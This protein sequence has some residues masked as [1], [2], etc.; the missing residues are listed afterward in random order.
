MAPTLCGVRRGLA[1]F[2]VML[3]LVL[4]APALAAAA[5]AP[6]GRTCSPAQGVRFCPGTVSTRVPSFDGVPLDVDVTLPATGN[7][8]FPTIVMLHGWGGS[9]TDFESTSGP[10]GNGNQ[11]YNYNNVYFAQQGYAALNYTEIGRA[12]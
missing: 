9:K 1:L 12:N 5:P 7:G 2:A 8:P 6:F 10:D 4:A 11:T 3:A